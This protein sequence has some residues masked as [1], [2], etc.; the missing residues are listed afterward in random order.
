MSYLDRQIVIFYS[1]LLIF[2]ETF[3]IDIVLHFLFIWV[4]SFQF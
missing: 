4:R 1:A 3:A 2:D